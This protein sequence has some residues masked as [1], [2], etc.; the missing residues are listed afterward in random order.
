M[1]TDPATHE[2]L[3]D[4]LKQ[5]SRSFYL[6][7]NVLPAGVRDQMGLSYLFARAADTIADTDLIDRGQRLKYLNQFRAQFQTHKIDW[8]A[9]QEIQAVLIPHQKD[10][11]ESI[12]LQRLEDCLKLY[13][14]YSAGDRERIQWLMEVLPNGMEMD[15]T[16]FPGESA[17]QL[18]ALS[19]LDEL[20]QYTYYVAGCVGEFWTRMVC[21]HSPEMARWDVTKMS[22]MGVRFGKGLQLTNIVK[23]IAR[24]LHNGRCYVP[25]PLLQEAGLRPADL[26]D[27]DNLPKFRPVLNRLIQLAMAHLDE[28]WRYTLAIPRSEIRQRLA[29]MWPILLAGETLKRVLVAPDLLNP[30]VNVKAPRGTVYRVMAITILT[31]A[32]EYVATAYWNRLKGILSE[33]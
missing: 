1:S 26:L 3:H 19:T 5:V 9:I 17:G 29:C 13:E 18:T 7:L 20:D 25:E 31:C 14:T 33:P 24:D 30:A 15:L 23:D 11:A 21:A 2:L 4:I 22:T 16:R 8:K 10:S 28:G 27:E 32:N 12:L 6:T